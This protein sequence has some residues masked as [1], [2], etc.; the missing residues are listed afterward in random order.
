MVSVHPAG[1]R[2]PVECLVRSEPRGRFSD[3][4]F[5]SPWDVCCAGCWENGV[6][7]DGQNAESGLISS[8][9]GMSS[10]VNVVPPPISGGDNR[11]SKEYVVLWLLLP[12]WSVISV[13]SLKL[14]PRSKPGKKSDKITCLS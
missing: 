10:V 3:E 14:K 11:D 6:V 1:R 5:T 7:Q 4:R 8:S 13:F 12:Y 9:G 2:Y